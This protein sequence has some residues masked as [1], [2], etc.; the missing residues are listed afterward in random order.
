[1]SFAICALF[2]LRGMPQQLPFI[3]AAVV[4]GLIFAALFVG[5]RPK[6]MMG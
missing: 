4:S 5:A 3:A 2:S 1:L 6:R